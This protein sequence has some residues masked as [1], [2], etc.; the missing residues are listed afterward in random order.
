MVQS[1][2][3]VLDIIVS[4][5]QCFGYK[6]STNSSFLQMFCRCVYKVHSSTMKDMLQLGK[7]WASNFFSTIFGRVFIWRSSAIL[8]LDV[9][10]LHFVLYSN[11]YCSLNCNFL[12]YWHISKYLDRWCVPNWQLAYFTFFSDNQLR[13]KYF[14]CETLIIWF[15]VSTSTDGLPY[16]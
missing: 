10:S 13:Y 11:P 6:L 8:F 5:D 3:P 16:H 1:R 15:L 2:S 7:L 9:L 12:N 4:P 14:D